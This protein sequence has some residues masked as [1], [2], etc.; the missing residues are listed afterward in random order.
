LEVT[1]NPCSSKDF[2]FYS[3]YPNQ[4]SHVNY[5]GLCPLAFIA[6]AISYACL[7]ASAALTSLGSACQVSSPIISSTRETT[8]CEQGW[9]SGPWEMEEYHYHLLAC[10]C[11]VNYRSEHYYGRPCEK[12][13]EGHTHTE[14]Y[15]MRDWEEQDRGDR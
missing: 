6:V 11:S 15:F 1:A 14:V 8:L 5:T 12:L 9:Q 13:T 3:L 10:C 4:V 7:S 2:S